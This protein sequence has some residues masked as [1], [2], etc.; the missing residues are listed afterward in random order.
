MTDIYMTKIKNLASWTH[1]L[2][3]LHLSSGFR[4]VHLLIYNRNIHI[5]LCNE[6]LL[7]MD[8]SFNIRSPVYS[9]V[10]VNF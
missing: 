2:I 6:S 9:T 7:M 4:L 10:V 5:L 3:G 8:V 1:T